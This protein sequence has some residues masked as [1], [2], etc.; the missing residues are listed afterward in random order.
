[1]LVVEIGAVLTT[2]LTFTGEADTPRWFSATVAVWL[3]LTV[4]FGNLAEAIA[5][6]RGRAQAAS[7]R[8]MRTTTTAPHGGRDRAPRRRAAPRRRRGRRGRRGHPR[9]RHGHRGHRVR[10][11]VGHHRRVRAGHPGGRRRPLGRHR[12]HARPVRPDRG[13]D[14]AGAG[15][16]VPRPHD[17]P[18]RG[19]R[20]P[21]DAE[22]DRPEHPARRPHGDLPRGGRHAAAVRRL[23]GHHGVG[24]DARR[25]A[26]R[27]HPD[28]D[29]RA[30]LRDRHRG[31]GP[32]RA[33]QRAR[34]LRARGRG[35]RRR[36]RPAPRQDRHHHPRQPPGRGVRADARRLRGRPR[37]G[38][39]ARLA[40]RRDAGGALDR[41]ARQA[42]RTARARARAAGGD[43]RAR[44]RRRRA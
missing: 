40:G 22:R 20:A 6:G 2:I 36:R 32:A 19:R 23:R 42:V 21:Q 38:R 41:R 5:E 15:A 13:R 43:V 29:R 24:H 7:L 8:A 18:R 26:R 44:S 3:W 17:R 16:V 34:A 11:R 37:G 1:M 30:A 10:R 33:P 12:R 14:H 35:V 39:P 9:G 25:A 31:H 4:I 27:A 28:D